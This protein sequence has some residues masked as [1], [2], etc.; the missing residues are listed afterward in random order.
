MK[1]YWS[2]LLFLVCSIPLQAQKISFSVPVPLGGNQ[3]SDKSADLVYFQGHYYMAWKEPGTAGS[4][5]IATGTGLPLRIEQEININVNTIARPAFAVAGQQLYLFWIDKDSTISYASWTTGFN[6]KEITSHKLP[7]DAANLRC[8]AGVTA[9]STSGKIMLATHAD[10]KDRLNAVLC[11]P[12]ADGFLQEAVTSEIKGARSATFPVVTANGTLLRF[13]W[14]KAGQLYCQEYN[15]AQGD[16]AKRKEQYTVPADAPPAISAAGDG[17]HIYIWSNREQQNQLQYLLSGEGILADAATDLP[18]YFNAI[19]PVTLAAGDKDNYVMIFPG[20]DQR[21]YIS[22][23]ELYDPAS[24]MEHLLLPGKEAYTLKDIVLPGAHDAG[25]S[26]LTAVGGKSTYTIN[27]CNTLTQLLPVARQLEAGMRMFDLR[28]DLYRGILY[29]KHAPSDCMDDAVGGGYGEQ[30]DSVL[31][32]VGRFLDRHPKEIILLSFCHFCDRHMPV[33]D[34]AKAVIAT[35]GKDRV[36]DAGTRAMKDIPLRELAGKVLISFEEYHFPGL[37]V[38]ANTMTDRS[39]AFFNYKRAYSATN[40]PDRLFAGQKSFFENLKGTLDA[41]DLVRLDWQLT[42]IGQEA[43]LTCGQFQSDKPNLLLDGALLLTN[44]IKK[45]KSIINL[46]LTGNRY[47]PGKVMDWLQDG[48][49]TSEN[50]PNILYVDAAGNWITDFCIQLN[51]QPV[52]KK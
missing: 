29:A 25:M 6:E 47:L 33:E 50:K 28:I 24:W 5:R 46:A 13:C 19:Q 9:A 2:V 42:Q 14:S 40:V 3:K 32:A 8:I 26:V 37:A 11:T 36:L 21:L 4:L 22:Y 31:V 20:A 41:N 1:R 35:L 16:W 18:L 49:I 45:N 15:A 30:L 48:T 12:R 38:V 17:K 52:Y 34:Q 10:S 7:G 39:G 23:G 44:A 43:A 27:E 51:R